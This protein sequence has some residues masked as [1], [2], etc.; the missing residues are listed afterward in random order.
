MQ[1]NLD[2]FRNVSL[3]NERIDQDQAKDMLIQS[4]GQRSAQGDPASDM[5]LVEILD[6]PSG[7]VTTLKKI[8]TPQEPQMSPEEEAMMAQGGMGGGAP[9]AVEGGPPPAV[10]TILAQMES[11][12][13]GVQSVGQMG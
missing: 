5:A 12:G 8:F 1:E 10:Q 11:A 7:A 3:I 4:L 6:D 13:G 2:G 9:Q